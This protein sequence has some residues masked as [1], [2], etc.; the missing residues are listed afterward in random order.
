MVA[1]ARTAVTRPAIWLRPPD[2]STAAVFDRLPATPKPPNSPEPR[3]PAPTASSSWLA[4]IRS[5]VLAANRRAALRPS[6]SPTNA[7]AAPATTRPV[8]SLIET[9]GIDGTGRPWGTS[10][11]T[12]TPCA[13]RSIALET[14]RP[15][16]RVTSA[17]GTRG[18]SF[19]P[20]KSSAR[21]EA[22]TAKVTLLVSSI[23][24]TRS[25][26][27]L[28]TSPGGT[29]M[30]RMLGSSPMITRI[31]RPSTKPVTMGL[32]RNSASHPIRSTLAR[33]SS[34]PAMIAMPAAMAMAASS[35]ATGN[36]LISEPVR[37]ATVETGPTMSMREVPRMA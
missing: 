14:A 15:S 1:R 12:A 5:P 25:W 9:S 37:T 3:L 32:D 35:V 19:D 27:R 24:V 28:R 8:M 22:P 34:S 36:P 11:T 29:G 21:A 17:H 10:P 2:R 33:A 26:M 31:V 23:P 18:A 6:A 7:T 13:A 16:T 4:S 20:T 30:P